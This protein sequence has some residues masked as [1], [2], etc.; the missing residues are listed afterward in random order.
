MA[1]GQ[2]GTRNTYCLSALNCKDVVTSGLAFS[3]GPNIVHEFMWQ[4]ALVSVAIFVGEGLDNVYAPP[5][6]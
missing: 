3:Q 6:I 5:G 2:L 4:E 1:K